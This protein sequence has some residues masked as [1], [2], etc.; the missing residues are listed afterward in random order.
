[1]VRLARIVVTAD[2]DLIDASVRSTVVATRWAGVASE[3]AHTRRPSAYL[4][5]LLLGLLAV[6][7]S[8]VTLW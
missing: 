4:V 1:V 2:R 5:W 8:G 7:V 6:G 3:R